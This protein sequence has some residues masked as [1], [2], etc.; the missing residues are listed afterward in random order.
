MLLCMQVFDQGGPCFGR[1]TRFLLEL[2]AVS[3]R[4]TGR[5]STKLRLFLPQYQAQLK[6]CEKDPVNRELFTIALCERAHALT[7]HGLRIQSVGG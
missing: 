4:A 6:F 3:D 2:F 5:I 1:N 7:D